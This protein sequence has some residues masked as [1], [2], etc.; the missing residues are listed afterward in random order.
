MNKLFKIHLYYA[1]IAI[2]LLILIVYVSLL[3]AQEI[4]KVGVQNLDKFVHAF[5]YFILA[6]FMLLGFV[7]LKH[8][9]IFVKS[10]PILLS[11]F[12]GFLIEILQEYTTSTRL[13]EIFDILANGIGCML[14]FIV[15]K[16]QIFNKIKYN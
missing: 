6:S 5:I 10:I 12:Y 3:P 4:P 9:S 1:A 16:K 11:F 7:N 14:A 15:M 13:F 8:R 2:I